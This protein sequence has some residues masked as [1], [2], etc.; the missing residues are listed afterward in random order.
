M[1]WKGQRCPICTLKPPWNHHTEES[2]FEEYKIIQN[3]EEIPKNSPKNIKKKG[4]NSSKRKINNRKE[5]S[6][7]FSAES[8]MRLL[9]PITKISQEEQKRN[10]RKTGFFSNPHT[11]GMK[12]YRNANMSNR[13]NRSYYNREVRN[14]DFSLKSI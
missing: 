2:F 6:K 7:I 8:K 4:E 1:N 12:R 9:S 10:F 11:P 3:T 5:R 14:T 13:F